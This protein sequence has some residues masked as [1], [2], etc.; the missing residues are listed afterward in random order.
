VAVAT[1]GLRRD[2]HPADGPTVAAMDERAADGRSGA[3]HR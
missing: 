2:G 1:A 3:R